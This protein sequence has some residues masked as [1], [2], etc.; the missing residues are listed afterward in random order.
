LPGSHLTRDDFLEAARAAFASS[1][2]KRPVAVLV[3]SL[4]D[5]Q[6][7]AERY[8]SDY[9]DDVAEKIA[10]IA[11][12]NL[13][14]VDVVGRDAE[15]RIVVV[16]P[17]ASGQDARSVGERLC[18]AVR[19]HFFAEEGN[20]HPTRLTISVGAAASPD[21]GSAY[22]ALRVAAESA[23]AR[24]EAEGS[25]GALVATLAHHEALHRPLGI[26]RF[27]GR[28]EELASLVGWL[29]E[30]VAGKPRLVIIQGEEGTGT[31]TLV[32]QIKAEVRLRGGAMVSAASRDA[33]VHEPYGVWRA[34]L[35]A[36]NRLPNPPTRDWRELHNLVPAMASRGQPKS[37]AGS[38]YRLLEEVADFVRAS[39]ANQPL[40]IV[41]DEM[42][43][44]DVTSWDA[45]DQLMAKL[46]GDRLMVCV[47]TRPDALQATTQRIESLGKHDFAR[48]LTLSA[49]TRDEVKQW[50]EAA[51][52][53]QKVAREF[54][55]FLYRHT[56][57]NPF[58]IAQ[59]LHALLEDGKLW[60]T[61]G[62]WEWSPVSELRFPA[63]LPEL[64]AKRVNRFS[65]STQ[66]VLSIASVAG[67][68]FDVG[69]LAAAGAGSQAAVKLALSEALIAGL[70]RRT[71]DRNREGFAFT[72]DQIA[73]VL[74]D[75]VGRERR[76]HIHR[77]VAQAL[78]RRPAMG[79]GDIATH[80]D[81]AGDSAAAYRYAQIAAEDAERVYAFA[82][83][84]GFLQMA[85]RNA[86]SPAELAEARVKLAHSAET[87]GR[88]DEVEELCD[89]AIEWFEGQ[90]DKR[91]A[92]TL[93][94]TRERARIQLGE[95][96]RVALDALHDLDAKA[97]SLGLDHERVAI[98]TLAAQ[99]HARL[100]DTRKAE[101]IAVQ[102][103]EMAERMGDRVLLAEA[104][105]RRGTTILGEAPSRARVFYQQALELFQE[106]GDFRG[107]AESHVNIGAAAHLESKVDEATQAYGQSMSVA[108]AAG[109]PDVWGVAAMNLAILTGRAGDYDRARELLGEALGA[110][111]AIKQSRYQL[112][113]LYNMAHVERELG[114]WESARKLYEATVP[115][116]QRIGQS[117]IEIGAIAGLGICS[118]DLGNIQEARSALQ[119]I[120]VRMESRPDWF[121]GRELVEAFRVRMAAL[122]NDI[123]GAV[124]QLES[125]LGLAEGA[126]VYSAV[127]LTVE[128]AEAL[129][130]HTAPGLQRFVDRYAS[131]V[132]QLG[133]ARMTRRY[134][135]LAGE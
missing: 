107:Q 114:A 70:V 100:G 60:H 34:L 66:A 87:A 98:L 43:W 57:G 11:R 71:F 77:Q 51:F 121:Q 75:L 73:A 25:D 110:F 132:R 108:R 131:R 28:K 61:D 67:R 45:L 111:A 44:A 32:H 105:M 96:A 48:R 106:T 9:V 24:V 41:L 115:L 18:A 89:L 130:P 47:I 59:L 112:M 72:H 2:S 122:D 99:A 135:A 20:S 17:T 127:W 113:A 91:R 126:D 129:K 30:A 123:E 94:R 3:V 37:Q 119:N 50:L 52:H 35:S 102:G 38:Q 14:G 117:D 58:F 7:L 134:E 78:E 21:H 53:G 22:D 86:T 95:P 97:K 33:E 42:Q 79:A 90:G 69:L 68:E 93:R 109:M 76:Q 92:L 1:E 63:G 133:F 124:V 26:D 74:F 49:L 29:D 13:R 128:C 10:E 12:W 116:A 125:A 46:E 65:S 83:A 82:A 62:R 84:T 55:A 16:L 54:L 118:L 6:R 39:A 23:R 85:A 36:L 88:F 80:H 40:V 15:D 4:D 56:E 81:L 120:L 31:A 8:G 101:Q 5:R 27:A 19:T 64:I 103:I 104:L